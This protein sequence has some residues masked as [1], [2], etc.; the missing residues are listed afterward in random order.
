MSGIA[1]VLIFAGKVIGLFGSFA[2]TAAGGVG[3]AGF[4]TS[5]AIN[6][7]RLEVEGTSH[8]T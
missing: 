8:T 3:V 1:E 6:V 2:G 7:S 5:A 4:L